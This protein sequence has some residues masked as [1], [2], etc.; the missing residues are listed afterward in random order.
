MNYLNPDK[1]IIAA[2]IQALETATGLRVWHKRVPKNVP[3]PARYIIL[4]SLTKNETGNYKP[5]PGEGKNT[6][7]E[8]ACTIDVNIYNV[9]IAGYTD[10]A[11]VYDIEQIV[12]SVV[13]SGIPILNFHNKDT[14]ILES[15]DL[16]VET[17][18]QSIDRKLIKFDHRLNNVVT[19]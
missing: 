5:L 3:T 10:A 15:L 9:N 4:D 1:Y 14:R 7:F 16:S 6:H 12:M 13:R 2:Y 8:W 11:V 19:S 17:S 18:T